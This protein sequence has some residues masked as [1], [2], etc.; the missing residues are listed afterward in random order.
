MRRAAAQV[1]PAPPL[2]RQARENGHLLP[3]HY[4][5]VSASSRHTFN[6]VM[7]AQAGIHAFLKLSLPRGIRSEDGR[8]QVY[9]VN[10]RGPY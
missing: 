4:N 3:F 6:V 9:S 2:T 7:P 10:R 1:K 8:T 5:V